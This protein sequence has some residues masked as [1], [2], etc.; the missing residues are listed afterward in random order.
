MG[1]QVLVFL[2]LALLPTLPHPVHAE[3][4]GQ[5]VALHRFFDSVPDDRRNG[6][7]NRLT[8]MTI[9]NILAAYERGIFPWAEAEWYSPPLRGVLFLDEVRISRSDRKI[10]QRMMKS[11]EYRVT[12]DMD[13]NG[14]IR[15]CAE[16]QRHTS[17]CTGQLLPAGEW[18]TPTFV[19]QYNRLFQN[20]Y[21]HSIEVW[22]GNKL[23]G[24]LY[25]VF[26]HGVFSGESMFRLPDYPNVNKLALAHLLQRLSKNGHTFIDTQM[27]IGLV[28]K[29]GARKIPRESFLQILAEAHAQNNP[30]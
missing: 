11:G 14:V 13:F 6:L 8:P 27:A 28:G 23:V 1:S 7:V 17:T 24:G 12:E 22:H 18:L 26:V 20:G 16:M 5:G 21:A 25:G 29:W 10:I 15:G 4:H 30:Y 9:D 19:R 2:A 3:H